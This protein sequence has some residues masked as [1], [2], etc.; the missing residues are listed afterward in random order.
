MFA[1]VQVKQDIVSSSMFRHILMSKVLSKVVLT[2]SSSFEMMLSDI[3]AR[4]AIPR[5]V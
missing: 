4:E 2:I 1:N 3:V 5:G